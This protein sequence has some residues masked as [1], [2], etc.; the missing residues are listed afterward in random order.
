VERRRPMASASL[1]KGSGV[2]GGDDL[3]MPPL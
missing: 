2:G 1:S 3:D